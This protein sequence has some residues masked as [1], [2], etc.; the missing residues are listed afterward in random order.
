MRKRGCLAFGL[1]VGTV[2][3]WLAATAPEGF[4]G[5][6][7]WNAISA[8]GT[9]SAAGVGLYVW[10]RQKRDQN[11]RDAVEAKVA[12][13]IIEQE[14]RWLRVSLMAVRSWYFEAGLRFSNGDELPETELSYLRLIGERL[15]AP[16]SMKM[17][18]KLPLLGERGLHIAAVLA[19]LPSM[20]GN[21]LRLGDRTN[22]VD[23]HLL[24]HL[25]FNH[26]KICEIMELLESAGIDEI[27]KV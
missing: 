8:I 24:L 14:M 9:S 15:E 26:S 3:G 11:Q 18:N 4:H 22:K 13:A 23:D 27:P 1:A 19:R 12:W 10:W 5:L 21:A 17:A 6:F 20:Q 16:A 25:H 2:L 7:P